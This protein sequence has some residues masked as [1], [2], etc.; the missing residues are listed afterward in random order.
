MAL[1]HIFFA[2][3]GRQQYFVDALAAAAPYGFVHNIDLDRADPPDSEQYG[4]LRDAYVHLSGNSVSF[5]LHWVHP[6][7]FSSAR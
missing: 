2:H 4:R 7:L 6:P 5:E 3:A 1:P